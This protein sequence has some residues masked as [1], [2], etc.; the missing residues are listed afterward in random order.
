MLLW[1]ILALMTGGAVLA[2]LWPF[3]RAP[4]EAAAT[5]PDASAVYRDQ[6]AEIDAD[7]ARGLIAGSE[8][9]SARREISRR[10]LASADTPAVAAGASAGTARLAFAASLLCLPVASLGLYLASGNPALP[11]Q[12]LAERL[13]ASA[14][15][16]NIGALIARVEAR[17]RENPDDG[18]GWEV[19]APVYFRL[20]RYGD[21]A[22]AYEQAIRIL[23]PAPDRLVG[24]GESL[25]AG[26]SSIVGEKARQAFEKARAIDG[27]LVKPRF[28]L[29]IAHEQDGDWQKAA[30]SWRELLAEPDK[31]APWRPMVEERLKTAEAKTDIPAASPATQGEQAQAP[32]PTAEDV[33]AAQQMAPQ[34]RQAMIQQMVAGLADRLREQGG[35]VDEWTR[36]VRSYMVLNRKD[37][38]T[39]ALAQAREK[40]KD[41]QAALTRLSELAKG[42]GI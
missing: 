15:Q 35:S 26:D 4:R 10:I 28:W 12:P 30:A 7:L 11:D 32:G 18:R 17:L 29:G 22:D 41:D 21:A 19:L 1:I 27:T 37:D 5:G 33:A 13:A 23:G 24:Y 20:Q 9:E 42:L 38:A 2:V 14:N 39:A 3:L 16:Q 25:V 34:D 40:F 36:L 6:F 8:A 31:K